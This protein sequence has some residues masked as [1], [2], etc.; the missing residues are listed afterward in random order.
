[1]PRKIV[2]IRLDPEEI[3][4]L[5]TIALRNGTTMAS[6]MRRLIIREQKRIE[7]GAPIP[8]YSKSEAK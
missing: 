7:A 3:V 5:R 8:I 1:M 2:N 4:A 6:M